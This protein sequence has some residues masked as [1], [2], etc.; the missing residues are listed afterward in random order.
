MG[1]YIFGGKTEKNLMSNDLWIVKLGSKPVEWIKAE[2]EGKSPCPR[3][4]HSMNFFEERNFIIIYGG[5][6]ESN[7]E[8]CVLN[9]IFL[10]V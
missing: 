3:Y 1:I 8:S 5:K 9:D 2:T 7:N 4:L 6:N 10:F